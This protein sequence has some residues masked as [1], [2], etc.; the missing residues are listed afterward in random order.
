MIL[1]YSSHKREKIEIMTLYKIN[2]NGG[3]NE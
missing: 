1:S 3:R 2:L